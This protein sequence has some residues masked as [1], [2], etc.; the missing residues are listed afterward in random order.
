MHSTPPP[1]GSNT[2][3]GAWSRRRFLETTALATVS[4]PAV[5][6]AQKSGSRVV[7]GEGDYR[8][9]VVHDCVSLPDRYSWQT[10]HNV[11]VDRGGLLYVIHEGH[12]NQP[13]HPSI[14]VFDADGNI[15]VAEWVATGRITKLRR[16]G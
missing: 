14:F 5:V 10:T 16:L 1:T 11:A 15:F 2:R 9:E 3:S 6:T 7:V 12:R 8:Y 13:D 4:V